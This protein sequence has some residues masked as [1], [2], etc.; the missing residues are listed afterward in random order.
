M[1]KSKNGQIESTTVPN[2]STDSVK[3]ESGSFVIDNKWVNYDSTI[4]K[5]ND[6]ITRVV[7][8]PRTKFFRNRNNAVFLMVGIHLQDGLKVIEGEQV[9]FT[10]LKAVPI[11]SGF[12]V[13]PILGIILIQDGTTD[14]NLGYKPL[15]PYYIV[16]FSGTGN[17]LDKNQ[18]G[19]KGVDS[20]V[21]GVT[22][23]TGYTGLEGPLAKQGE[24]GFI[25]ET[26][27]TLLAERG[28][29][30]PQ[31]VTGISWDIHLKLDT[32]FSQ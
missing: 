30:G 25:G 22:G 18:G 15:Q 17:V 1:L 4:F 6:Y 19:V 27:V 24:T 29:T 7:V 28:F 13:V 14:L 23:F 2:F 9:R 20:D 11:P 16:H 10:T 31:G 21:L 32:F 26:G 3:I 5:V 8:A 12:D